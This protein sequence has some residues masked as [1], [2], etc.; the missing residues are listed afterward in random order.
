[1]ENE[2]QPTPPAQSWASVREIGLLLRTQWPKY[3][4]D[5]LVIILSITISFMFDSFKEESGRKSS[6][7]AY[8]KALHGDI[9]SDI[10]ELKK[11]IA[12]TENVVAKANWLVNL[13]DD[14]NAINRDELA[15]AIKQVVER[16]NFNS[17]DA[18][19]SDLTSSGNMLLVEDMNLKAALFEYY[20]FYESIRAV[21]VAERETMNVNVAPYLIKNLSI[22]RLAKGATGSVLHQGVELSDLMHNDDFTNIFSIRMVSRAELL[23]DYRIELTSAEKIDSLLTAK[24]K[25]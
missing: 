1:M 8:L 24:I 19:F 17:K 3:L 9:T 25:P 7:Q 13:P 6:E 2:S 18:T 14:A 20:R 11:V 12:S 22:K 23:D 15:A 5:V 4:V 16:P 10:L 21:E